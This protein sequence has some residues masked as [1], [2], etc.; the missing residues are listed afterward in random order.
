MTCGDSLHDIISNISL[1]CIIYLIFVLFGLKRCEVMDVLM[2][3]PRFHAGNYT[4]FLKISIKRHG[5]RYKCHHNFSCFWRSPAW[6]FQENPLAPGLSGLSDLLCEIETNIH[7]SNHM[8]LVLCSIAEVFNFRTFDC[9]RLAKMLG[10]FDYI[11]LPNPIDLYR[12][13]EFD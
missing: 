13:M 4:S 1:R 11:R 8:K 6:N 2:T 3:E 5:A 7:D 10:E 12:A 9:V